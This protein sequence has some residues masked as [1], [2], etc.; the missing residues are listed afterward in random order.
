MPRPLLVA[1]R[2]RNSKTTS[3]ELA[4]RTDTLK[5]KLPTK[6][7]IVKLGQ[8]IRLLLTSPKAVGE[9][10]NARPFLAGL[11]GLDAVPVGTCR[12][13]DKALNV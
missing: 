3:L 9:I 13:N 10:R 7:G 6:P 1:A 11:A 4:V 8:L 5:T 2:T 12:G